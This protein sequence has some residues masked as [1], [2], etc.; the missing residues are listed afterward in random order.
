MF[1]ELTLLLTDVVES[2]RLNGELGDAVMGPLWAKHDAV[3]RSLM[4]Q[5]SG[6]EVGR[7]DGFL[8]LFERAIDALGFAQH[9]HR[10]LR[11]LSIP[12]KARIGIHTGLIDPRSNAES[13]IARGA[14]S[15]EVDGLALPLT[16]RIMAAA[17]GGQTLLSAECRRTIE[18]SFGDEAAPLGLGWIGPITPP[19][20]SS[21]PESA[22]STCNLRLVSQGFWRFKGLES[23]IQ[24]YQAGDDLDDFTPPADSDKAYRVVRKAGDWRPV[25]DIPHGLPS[26]ADRFIGRTESL[27]KIAGL[28]ERG[29]R[30][31]SIL[32]MGGIGKTR[33]S[34]RF[35]SKWL[36]DY[37]GG[38]WFCDLSAATSKNG[39]IYAMTQALNVPLDKHD[40]V[41]SIGAAIAA[42]G[43][44]LVILDN[45]EQV[46]VHATDTLGAWLSRAPEAH[47][48]ATSRELLG[49]TGEHAVVVEPLPQVDASELLID[50]MSAAG[51][52]LPLIPD[53]AAAIRPLI[54]LLDGLPLAIEL[55]ASRAS[56]LPPSQLLARMNERFKLLARSR[57]TGDRQ[58]TLR[59]TL[60]W[61]WGLLSPI[62]RAAFSQCS[63]F[64][65]GFS[66]TA[67]E[68]VLDLSEG[69]ESVWI[70]DAVQGLVEKSLL[71]RTAANRLDFLRSVHEYARERLSE[72][73]PD[74]TRSAERRH[75]RYF[76]SL[77]EQDAIADRCVETENLVSACRRA[78]AAADFDAAAAALVVAWAALNLTGP[79][80]VAIEISQALNRVAYPHAMP[81]SLAALWVS[82][83]ARY[84]AGDVAAARR[85]LETANGIETTATMRARILGALGQ[86]ER[87]LGHLDRAEELLD[88]GLREAQKTG[89]AG[90]IGR[91]HNALG[92]LRFAQ[93]RLASARESFE[94]GLGVARS[95]R[96]LKQQAAL[97]GNI[98]VV[99][100]KSG[101]DESALQH[102][103]AA[104]DLARAIGDRRFEGN[105][106]SNIGLFHHHNGNPAQALPQLRAA[107]EIAE[108]AGLMRLL[109]D[110]HCNLGLVE[111]SQGR[112][113]AALQRQLEAIRIADGLQDRWLAG[114]CRIFA[115]RVMVHLDR[116]TE[117]RQRLHEAEKLLEGSADLA[118]LGLLDCALAD[119]ACKVGRLDLADNWFSSG[120]A[121]ANATKTAP[122]S[123]LA[124]ELRRIGEALSSR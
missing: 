4:G 78:I 105:M 18:S 45:F 124:R 119:W 25:R 30:L 60:D 91:A 122:N 115:A 47:F 110:V 120:V 121:R 14:P 42:R 102:Y 109:V 73:G 27:M 11:E 20:P 50:R 86:L 19:C 48:L 70:A 17:R 10:A 84:L 107:Q 5:W 36:G 7:S 55:A 113:E 44:C 13:D 71:R 97:L 85:D 26:E 3:A 118:V 46:S 90:L 52:P 32:G 116:L 100:R 40:P 94:T 9:Y 74:A 61:S 21:A 75:W 95:A 12:L 92:S 51:L 54:D 79:F 96:D 69:G 87:S 37:E 63:V 112:I 29:V 31:V 38:A 104:L 23:P 81:A 82:G 59:A 53:E 34:L 62:E 8:V 114:H 64:E 49:I 98:G 72:M 57:R 88:S 35:A 24:V 108:G 103:V 65:G 66:L 16:A 15:V 123:E 43:R 39:I 56:A 77:S 2:T 117:A 83:S 67:A 68:H 111:E 106:R 93:G 80:S 89:D 6:R 28:F 22:D 99:D 33:L 1:R 41:R 101:N 58:S 76:S